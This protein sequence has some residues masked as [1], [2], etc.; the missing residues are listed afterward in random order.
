MIEE[1]PN[2][3]AIRRGQWKYIQYH[4]N[5]HRRAL[6]SP[7][8]YDLSHDVAEVN[9]VIADHPQVAESL[10]EQLHVLQQAKGIRN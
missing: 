1:A 6:K 7:E 5:K 4:M 10:R 2:A 8:L 9:N 3:T